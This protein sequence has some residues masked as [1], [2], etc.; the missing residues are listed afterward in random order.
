MSSSRDIGAATD[1]EEVRQLAIAVALICMDPQMGPMHYGGALHQGLMGATERTATLMGT[2]VVGHTT[3]FLAGREGAARGARIYEHMPDRRKSLLLSGNAILAGTGGLGTLEEIAEAIERG[4]PVVILGP[5][6]Y[7]SPIKHLLK[8]M[9]G[10]KDIRDRVAF[11]TDPE[12]AARA[13]I[14][15]AKTAD[16]SQFR[17]EDMPRPK[18]QEIGDEKAAVIHLKRPLDLFLWAN[19]MTETQLGLAAEHI[20]LVDPKGRHARYL[21]PWLLE[22]HRRGTISERDLS[23]AVVVKEGSREAVAWA[24]ANHVRPA[25]ADEGDWKVGNWPDV[26]RAAR[27]AVFEVA[28]PRGQ[29]PL[30]AAIAEALRAA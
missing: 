28:G 8:E 16:P 1:F 7:W 5:K 24:V 27:Q 29:H 2:P 15:M 25:A 20:V 26:E 6:K 12:D 4:I 18:I 30:A 10:W 13:L 17:R 19:A 11:T 9:K 22:A 21:K 14:R 3:K 23:R